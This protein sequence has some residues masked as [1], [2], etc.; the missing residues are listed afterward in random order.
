MPTV[1]IIRLTDRNDGTPA[2]TWRAGA[3]ATV[4][5]E[6]A[7]EL[8]RTGRARLADGEPQ[9]ERTSGYIETAAL[10]AGETPERSG[11]APLRTRGRQPGSGD[12][13]S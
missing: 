4:P 1:R 9:L 8:V 7:R 10:D 13:V 12:V 5:L 2:G 11:P 6:E 3:L